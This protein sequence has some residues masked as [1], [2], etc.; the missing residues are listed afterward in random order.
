MI[1]ITSSV[2]TD[3]IFTLD[4]NHSRKYLKEDGEYLVDNNSIAL[5]WDFKPKKIIALSE[6][7]IKMSGQKPF[8]VISVCIPFGEESDDSELSESM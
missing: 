6:T 7:L 1:T 3:K 8:S 4:N 5:M 2:Y